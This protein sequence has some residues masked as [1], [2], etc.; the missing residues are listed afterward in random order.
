MNDLRVDNDRGSYVSMPS[1]I[2]VVLTWRGLWDLLRG[3]DF[4]IGM[5]H[6]KRRCPGASR[7]VQLPRS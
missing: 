2:Q 4:W 5:I 3:R 1:H 6:I 7:P